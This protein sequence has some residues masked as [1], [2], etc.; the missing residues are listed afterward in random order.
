MA[1]YNLIVG[2]FSVIQARTDLCIRLGEI[3]ICVCYKLWLKFLRSLYGSARLSAQITTV[4]S[5]CFPWKECWPCFYLILEIS[6]FTVLRLIFFTLWVIL[7]SKSLV[8]CI[9]R[10][11]LICVRIEFLYQLESIICTG[12]IIVCMT[13]ELVLCKPMT[14]TFIAKLDNL[15]HIPHYFHLF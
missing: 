5:F 1:I 13:N 3:Y 15:V 11:P 10:P 4:S 8:F 12:F 2:A 14:S 6:L 7:K 9:S